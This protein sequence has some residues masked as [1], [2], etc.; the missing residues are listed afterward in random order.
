MPV[1]NTYVSDYDISSKHHEGTKQKRSNKTSNC[2]HPLFKDGNLNDTL[3]KLEGKDE[4]VDVFLIFEELKAVNGYEPPTARKDLSEFLQ[5]KR[6]PFVKCFHVIAVH[7]TAQVYLVRDLH[8]TVHAGL[9][10]PAIALLLQAVTHLGVPHIYYQASVCAI[11]NEFLRILNGPA[12]TSLKSFHKIDFKIPMS[13]VP[14]QSVGNR[15]NAQYT[16]GVSS[17]N[18]KK[19][20]PGDLWNKQTVKEDNV[21]DGILPQFAVLSELLLEIDPYQVFYCGPVT[22]IER[23]KKHARRLMEMDPLLLEE[24]RDKNVIESVSG[25]SNVYS[26]DNEGNMFAGANGVDPYCSMGN[27]QAGEPNVKSKQAIMKKK[28]ADWKIDLRWVILFPPC[29]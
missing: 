14:T 12:V 4:T 5:D 26:V 20:S 6:I 29:G 10:R 15:W 7:P 11:E 16:W 24:L 27:K 17:L 3:E 28:F 23:Q 22:G 25:I 13:N 1:E 21:T 8:N 18:M 19:C 2:F 9:L